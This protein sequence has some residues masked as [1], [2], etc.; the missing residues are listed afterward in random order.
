VIYR[1]VPAALVVVLCAALVSAAHGADLRQSCV[2]QTIT[3]MQTQVSVG[4]GKLCANGTAISLNAQLSLPAGAW[5][6]YFHSSWSVGA[7]P[8]PSS[9]LHTVHVRGGT[10]VF[11]YD[12]VP[13]PSGAKKSAPMTEMAIVVKGAKGCV[14][15]QHTLTGVALAPNCPQWATT[16]S[17]FVVLPGR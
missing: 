17:G 11:L 7:A 15:L 1:V 13:V 10:T 9:A 3:R 5:T 8:I 14:I 4:S 16:T 6:V 12:R 2:D